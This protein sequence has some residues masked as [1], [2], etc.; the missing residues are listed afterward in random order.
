[1]AIDLVC[2][3]AKRRVPKPILRRGIDVS[4]DA[5]FQ[6]ANHVCTLIIEASA[7]DKLSNR[8]N[9]RALHA[10]G[11]F[12]ALCRLLATLL[13]RRGDRHSSGTDRHGSSD[14]SDSDRDEHNRERLPSF[15]LSHTPYAKKLILALHALV[16]GEREH[17]RNFLQATHG[18][19]DTF[20]VHPLVRELTRA[21]VHSW[22]G[23]TIPEVDGHGEDYYLRYCDGDR[24]E[25]KRVRGIAN[26][27][28]ELYACIQ[29][30]L[31]AIQFEFDDAK[32]EVQAA[33]ER[34]SLEKTVR[35]VATQVGGSATTSLQ[36]VELIEDELNGGALLLASGITVVS[37]QEAVR[38][39][40]RWY[41]VVMDECRELHL[42]H[43]DEEACVESLRV[44]ERVLQE[45]AE[46]QHIF[47]NIHGAVE[48]LIR[49]INQIDEN[50]MQ[51]ACFCTLSLLR[52]SPVAQQAFLRHEGMRSLSDC[53][54]DYNVKI[55]LLAL[56]TISLLSSKQERCINEIRRTGILQHVVSILNEFP[57]EDVNIDVAIAAAD[58]LAHCV[59]DNVANQQLVHGRGG[60]DTLQRILKWCLTDTEHSE[61]KASTSGSSA[62]NSDASVAG[63]VGTIL[64][65]VCIALSNLA[66]RNQNIQSELRQNGILD[67]CISA[68]AQRVSRPFSGLK[69]ADGEDTSQRDGAAG[70]LKFRVPCRPL[71]M[72]MALLNVVINAVDANPVNQVAVGTEEVTEILCTLIGYTEHT[73][74]QL[75]LFSSDIQETEAGIWNSLWD[76][77][78]FVG[79]LQKIAALACLLASHLAWDNIVNQM[80]FAKES[81]IGQLLR[82]VKNGG[83]FHSML[84]SSDIGKRIIA[85][86]SRL[87]AATQKRPGPADSASEATTSVLEDAADRP[88]A[89]DTSLLEHEDPTAREGINYIGGEAENSHAGAAGIFSV[90]GDFD[91]SD[92]VQLYALMALINISY[93]N[94]RV[95][96]LI[97]AASGV[98]LILDR[99]SS[100]IYDVQKAAIFCLGNVVTNHPE[101]AQQLADAGGVLALVGVMNDIDED[102]I[103]KKAFTTLTSMGSIAVDVIMGHIAA[104][105]AGVEGCDG[106]G[107]GLGA[108]ERA[109]DLGARLLSAVA[110]VSARS[111]EYYQ[112]M[113]AA[114]G[115]SS[116]ASEWTDGVAAMRSSDSAEHAPT[117]RETSAETGDD[118]ANAVLSIVWGMLGKLLPVLNGMVY[119]DTKIREYVAVDGSGI[120]V[121]LHVMTRLLPLELRVVTA[122]TLANLT[123]SQEDH[124]KNLAQQFDAISVLATFL[125]EVQRTD[126]SDSE[127]ES[128]NLGMHSRRAD[129][130]CVI[131]SVMH[132]LVNMHKGCAL[133]MLTK[134]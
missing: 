105:S 24:A 125:G 19:D 61:T 27:S 99:L 74:P 35:E 110:D 127:G 9:V 129:T 118:E 28:Y 89:S 108:A 46:A 51:A 94:K 56:Q 67:V 60:L 2:A 81:R 126:M 100:S 65:N 87:A 66:F 42:Y 84:R 39:C 3:V 23:A 72:T 43:Y 117:S 5:W 120:P 122:Y 15:P 40:A 47:V 38:R 25:A 7:S 76:V 49:N 73:Q 45:G 86:C 16:S 101:N 30:L 48:Q 111:A 4:A 80:Q 109:A 82:L 32:A 93:H 91:G 123:Q 107:G 83:A 62:E 96:D 134:S 22:L 55:R 1:M 64:E 34:C 52:G 63:S 85:H 70:S 79:S 112:S 17:Q 53:L 78:S 75:P 71:Q 88:P 119:S 68:L 54:H 115:A 103:S 57:A 44:L 26:Q 13:R 31:S 77:G 36:I 97:N 95:H 106:V 128:D 12:D 102:E 37:C 90:D 98:D 11:V 29:L 92:E 114:G 8:S 20:L 121:L 14:W 18:K 41:S 10:A 132:N 116:K 124:I 59:N 33:L 58:V 131:M 133:Q 6:L 113:S 69:T 130:C 21:W 50:V 104:L